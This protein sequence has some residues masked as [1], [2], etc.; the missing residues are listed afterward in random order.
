MPYDLRNYPPNWLTEIRPAIL[1]RAGNRCEVCGVANYAVGY[2]WGEQ[3]IE[4]PADQVAEVGKRE[5]VFRIVLTI[6]HHPDPN[7]RNCDPANL[8]ALCQYH[9][10]LLDRDLHREARR[11]NRL[12]ARYAGQIPLGI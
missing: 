5:R 7:P 11:A 10:I 9:H 4:V 2:R 12:A 1:A 6:A 3:F 8:H